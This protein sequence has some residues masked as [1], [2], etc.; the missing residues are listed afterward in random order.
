MNSYLPEKGYL[1]LLVLAFYAIL[2]LLA[3]YL[4]LRYLLGALLPFLLAFAS[5]TLLRPI[6]LRVKKRTRMTERAAAFFALFLVL[7]LIA[8]AIALL[9]FAVISQAGELISILARNAEELG[10]EVSLAIDSLLDRLPLPSPELAN[11]VRQ[12]LSEVTSKALT[13]A[14]TSLGAS[15]PS[16]LASLLSLLPRLLLFLTVYLISTFA[17]CA[18]YEQITASLLSLLPARLEKPLSALRSQV[19][20]MGFSYLRAALILLLFTAVMLWVGLV[21]LGIPYA[22]LLSVVIAILDLLPILGTGTVLIPWAIFCLLTHRFSLGIGL[23]LVFVVIS[24]GKQLLE[25]R[26]VGKSIG[27]SPL[28]TLTA[29]YAGWYLF[30]LFGLLLFPIGAAMLL[31]FLKSRGENIP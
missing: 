27:L 7:T 26:I 6:T 11:T 20:L 5:A 29:T 28:L 18:R 16:Y 8:A 1:R 13:S 4:F 17:L 3:L 2:L 25:P 14:L 9:I 21:L 22:L 15:L 12:G 31:H 30:G 23:L 19:K 10:R 24:I